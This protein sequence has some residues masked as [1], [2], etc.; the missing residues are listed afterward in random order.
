VNSSELLIAVG[1][2]NTTL[3][4]G[5]FQAHRHAAIWPEPEKALHLRTRE[6][7]LDE[8]AAWCGDA[9]VAWRVASV[10]RE[11][12]ERLR[13]WVRSVRPQD[14]YRALTQPDLPLAVRLPSPERVGID[15]LAAAVGANALRDPARPAIVVDTGTA[16]TVNLVGADGAF[17]GGAILPGITMSA[18]ALFDNADL[19]PWVN[20]DPG[21]E[22][23]AALGKSTDEAI[24][25]GLYW[26]AV[27]SIREVGARLAAD[28]STSPEWFLTGGDAAF[29]APQLGPEVRYVPHLVLGGIVIAALRATQ[30]RAAR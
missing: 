12:Q 24:K 13:E 23:P 26:G 22:P 20:A 3:K 2:G 15:R 19:L 6:G 27:G 10:Q 29:L 30:P 18:R 9:P 8:L 28:L 17:L 25:G 16:I 14:D 5:L 4:A 11:A 1:I 7:S 21:S